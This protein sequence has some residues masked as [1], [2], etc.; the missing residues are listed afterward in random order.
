MRVVFDTNI[1]IAALLTPGG[2]AEEALRLVWLGRHELVV[3]PAILAEV[4]T[5]LRQ[6]FHWDPARIEEACKLFAGSATLLRPRI[7]HALLKDEPDNRILE[8][9]TEAGAQVIVTGD[10]ELLAVGRFEG[11]RISSLA[12]FIR[13][14]SG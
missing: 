2:R 3:S 8:C 10:K 14:I 1:Y 7:R 9:A 6:K 5:K 4:A 13:D 11:V 12:D